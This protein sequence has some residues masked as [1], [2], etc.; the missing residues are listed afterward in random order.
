MHLGR[1]GNISIIPNGTGV[2][3]VGKTLNVTS[4][5]INATSGSLNAGNLSIGSTPNNIISTN[6]IVNDDW[7][8]F[9][10]FTIYNWT[11]EMD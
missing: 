9:I 5:N 2:V 11:K 4:G 7:I 3:N 1:N 10:Y 8:V 6:T